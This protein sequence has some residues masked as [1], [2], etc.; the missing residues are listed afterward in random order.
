MVSALIPRDHLARGFDEEAHCDMPR[1]PAATSNPLHTS[2]G[3]VVKPAPRLSSVNL[4]NGSREG[5]VGSG[6]I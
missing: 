6:K 1:A 5:A 2:G 4:P 3:R